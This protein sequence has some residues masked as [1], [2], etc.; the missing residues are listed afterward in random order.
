MIIYLPP[1]DITPFIPVL[2]SHPCLWTP[3]STLRDRTAVA[4]AA[5]ESSAAAASRTRVRLTL[6]MCSVFMIKNGILNNVG[7][8]AQNIPL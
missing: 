7:Q 2:L 4:A 1:P 3:S 6:D 8:H 5:R